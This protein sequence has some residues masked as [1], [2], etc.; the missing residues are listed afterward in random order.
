MLTWEAAG[1]A[2]QRLWALGF[3]SHLNTK[4]TAKPG[5]RY[6][7]RSAALADLIFKTQPELA[8]CLPPPLASSRP[9][10]PSLVACPDVTSCSRCNEP[11]HDARPATFAVPGLAR[12]GVAQVFQGC[13][14]FFTVLS[15]KWCRLQ[16]GSRMV[17]CSVVVGMEGW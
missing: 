10:L 14:W 8:L 6:R 1:D 15:R 7:M 5:G 9:K 4:P 13:V 11:G 3:N 17:A 12:K 16:T 2:F